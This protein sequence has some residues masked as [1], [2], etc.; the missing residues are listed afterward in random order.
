MAAGLPALLPASHS[1]F[2]FTPARSLRLGL[3]LHLIIVLPELAFVVLLVPDPV[4]VGRDQHLGLSIGA[5]DGVIVI[6]VA[7][8][9]S[10]RHCSGLCFVGSEDVARM[11]LR[12]GV[13]AALPLAARGRDRIVT[14]AVALRH[15]E[16][17]RAQKLRPEH[18]PIHV[19]TGIGCVDGH[20][21]T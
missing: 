8:L 20:A 4:V 21:C 7:T 3:G 17:L 15:L 1:S 11:R 2:G 13:V 19:F 12:H 18:V 16:R 9:A 5:V 6:F 14:L 10:C